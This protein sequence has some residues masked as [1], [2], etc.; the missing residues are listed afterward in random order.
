MSRPITVEAQG[1]GTGP[2]ATRSGRVLSVNISPGGIPKRPIPVGVV[3][4]AGL[5]DDGHNH[6]KHRTPQQ[7]IS[8]LDE[9]DMHALIAEGFALE[10]GAA[11]ENLTVRG[12]LVRDGALGDRLVFDGGVV[13]EITRVRTPCYVLDAIDPALRTAAIGRIGTYARV[14]TPGEI[15]PGEGVSIRA[16]GARDCFAPERVVG[17]ILVGGASSRMGQPKQDVRL[18]DGRTMLDAVEEA[19]RPIVGSIVHLG[20]APG[21]QRRARRVLADIGDGDAGPV[22][23]LRA[24]AAAADAGD[25]AAA[26]LVCP[27][28]MPHLAPGPLRRLLRLDAAVA[29]VFAGTDGRDFEPLPL[30]LTRTGL[31]AIARGAAASDERSLHRLI[32]AI[33]PTIVAR[34]PRVP[35]S[36]GDDD[37]VRMLRDVDTPEDLAS[38]SPS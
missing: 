6:A 3:R 23:G 29:R 11:G 35:G 20:E 4:C 1:H 30:V 16:D 31:D 33:G 34:P 27:C 7:A 36:T 9:E 8:L 13:L 14:L 12:A 24:L 28:D 32:R 38:C 19:M 26:F 37:P 17:A 22:G 15:R 21:A 25:D 5:K 2:T 18:P 10:P